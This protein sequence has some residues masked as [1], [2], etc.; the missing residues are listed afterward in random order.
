V[1][2]IRQVDVSTGRFFKD[3]TPV[4]VITFTTQEVLLFCYRKTRDVVVGAEDHTEQCNYAPV[5]TRVEELENGLTSGWE[6]I[7]VR[8]ILFVVRE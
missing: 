2:D 3:N 8:H 1:L 6:V 5:V 7:E 4:Y